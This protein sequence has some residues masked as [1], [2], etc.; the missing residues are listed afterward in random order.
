MYD[1]ARKGI[2]FE[3]KN[4]KVELFSAEVIDFDLPFYQIK[5]LCGKGFYVR[6]LIHD[7]GKKLNSLSHMVGLRRT[8]SG[9][10]SIESSVSIENAQN[11]LDKDLL[12]DLIIPAQDILNGFKIVNIDDFGVKKILTGTSI[13]LNMNYKENNKLAFLDGSNNLIAIGLL[14][15]GMGVPKKVMKN[16]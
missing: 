13:K 1:L 10:F 16:V 14:I 7:I 9:P 3:P 12:K 4:R 6:S 15:D 11:K 8:L 2:D 5:I